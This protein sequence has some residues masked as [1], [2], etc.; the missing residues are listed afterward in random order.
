MHLEGA[1]RT[2]HMGETVQQCLSEPN[3]SAFNMS[4][5]ICLPVPPTMGCWRKQEQLRSSVGPDQG[6][7]RGLRCPFRCALSLMEA[8]VT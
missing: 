7:H 8:G 2:Q 6:G 5:P 1:E 3:S 4:G